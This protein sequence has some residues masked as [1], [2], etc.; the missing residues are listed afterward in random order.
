MPRL[1]ALPALAAAAGAKG[2]LRANDPSIPN[3]I[4]R[5]TPDGL[6]YAKVR[7]RCRRTAATETCAQQPQCGVL[8]QVVQGEDGKRPCWCGRWKQHTSG[9]RGCTDP[10]SMPHARPPGAPAPP[11]QASRLP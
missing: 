10:A 6:Q 8:M 1:P 7:R 5:A 4:Y 11:T 3:V 2:G 9:N